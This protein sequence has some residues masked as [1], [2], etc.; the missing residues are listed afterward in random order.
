[1]ATSAPANPLPQPIDTPENPHPHTI[2]NLVRQII[3]EQLA[4]LKQEL[5][6]LKQ[7]QKCTGYDIVYMRSQLTA[8]LDEISA[9]EDEEEEQ[10][11]EEEKQ[12]EAP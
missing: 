2:D 6:R 3:E 8:L 1:M 9:E 12:Q 5:V 11:E 10:E 7:L 4:P